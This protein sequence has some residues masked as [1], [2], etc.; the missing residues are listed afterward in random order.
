MHVVYTKRTSNF[1]KGKHYRN[2]EY[3]GRIEPRAEKVTIEG[4][5]PAIVAAYES[6]EIE[7]EVIGASPREEDPE[8]PDLERAYEEKFGKAP[9]ANMKTETIR[10]KLAEAAA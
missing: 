9:S 5:F 3:F 8:R 6:R 7:V 4:D 1:E 2:P 10:K